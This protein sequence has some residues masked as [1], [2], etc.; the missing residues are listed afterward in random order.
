[1]LGGTAARARCGRAP[2][3][4]RPGAAVLESSFPTPVPSRVWDSRG[5]RVAHTFPAKRHIQTC[6]DASRDGRYC[7][8]SSSGSAGEG[9]EATV[10]LLGSKS[11]FFFFFW[12]FLQRPRHT[13]QGSR[14]ALRGS[15][16]SHWVGLMLVSPAGATAQRLPALSLRWVCCSESI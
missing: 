5:L 13:A 10:S 1:M 14:S 9:G 8:S 11:C 2:R 16:C 6:C 12:Y 4:A 7:L 3:G 15:A